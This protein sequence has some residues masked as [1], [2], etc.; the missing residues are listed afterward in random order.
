MDIYE[1][2]QKSMV[3]YGICPCLAITLFA[4]QNIYLWCHC[5]FRLEIW[6]TIGTFY[7]IVIADHTPCFYYLFR[8][9]CNQPSDCIRKT[10]KFMAEE[11]EVSL[12]IV[13]DGPTWTWAGSGRHHPIRVENWLNWPIIMQERWHSPAENTWKRKIVLPFDNEMKF[14]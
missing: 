13:W 4:K 14:L 11:K 6:S 3:I 12:V 5:I 9:L 1:N 2:L 8:V 10:A 7:W